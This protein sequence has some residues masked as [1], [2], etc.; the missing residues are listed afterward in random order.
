MI[1]RL[2]PFRRAGRDLSAHDVLG[3]GAGCAGLCRRTT[4]CARRRCASSTSLMVDDGERFFFQPCFSPV[5]DTGHRRLRAGAERPGQPGA[6][7]GGRLAAG[8]R[9]PAQG[10]LEREAARHRAFRLG[11]LLP[12]RV[13]PGYRRHRHG[14]AG[15][16]PGAAGLATPRRRRPATGGRSTGCWPC[17][18]A[19]AAGRPSTPITTGSF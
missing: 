8:R 6:R 7:P 15:A 12:Q 13:L 9:G 11:F 3:D 16:E 14:D 17:N 10:R 19:M 1:E 18:R 4:R 5:W 2:R